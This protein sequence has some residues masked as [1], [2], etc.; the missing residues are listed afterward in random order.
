MAFYL[1]TYTMT[2][3]TGFAPAVSDGVLSLACCSSK[4]RRKVA[5]VFNEENEVYFMGVMGK[6]F[7][8]RCKLSCEEFAYAP[9]YIAKA[10][11]VVKASEYFRKN[12]KYA[13]P[14][15][16]DQVYLFDGRHWS[17]N[18]GNP[19]AKHPMSEKDLLNSNSDVFYKNG[20]KEKQMSDV[21]LAK[22]FV[23]FGKEIVS[24]KVLDPM[25]S[26]L[27]AEQAREWR[28]HSNRAKNIDEKK[29]IAVFEELLKQN[30]NPENRPYKALTEDSCGKGKGH[31]IENKCKKCTC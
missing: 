25:F 15:R 12:G 28:A 16:R 21:I 20:S 17:S 27:A 11:H 26:V 4:L 3:D 24:L 7:A 18:K 10:D 2:C 29:F 14:H 23:Y 9:L 8:E 31:P 22:E 1:F 13:A 5:E 19:H 30:I 6:T